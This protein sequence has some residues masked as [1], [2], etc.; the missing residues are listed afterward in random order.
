M[1]GGSGR[2]NITV[3]ACI[4]AEGKLLPP[5]IIYT[6]KYVLANCT[7]GGPLGT[8][9]AVSTN[10]WMTIAA[11][12]DWFQNLFI[13]SLPSERPILL[14]LDGHSSHISH[15]VCELAI[16]NNIHMLKLPPHFLQPLDVGVFKPMKAILYHTRR[17]RR[18]ITKRDFPSL[19]SQ[20]WRQ[21][22][23]ETCKGGFR[24]CGI[25]PFNG[26]FVPSTSFKHSQ[27]FN[28][29]LLQTAEPTQS[30]SSQ[31]TH[32]VASSSQGTPPVASSSQGTLLHQHKSHLQ[33]HHNYH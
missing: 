10:G 6:G 30:T 32:P 33:S 19:L 8:R 9:F 7:N 31:G 21:Y 26:D 1:I 15:E 28:N 14:I 17:E 4:N 2:E 13:P 20:V 25:Y 11:Y 18:P 5:Y 27:P 16:K 29:Q 24:K 22:N 23:E 12:I 3:Q